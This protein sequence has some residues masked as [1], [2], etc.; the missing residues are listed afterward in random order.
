LKYLQSTVAVN[1]IDS[2]TLQRIL[3]SEQ[4]PFPCRPRLLL[5]VLPEHLLHRPH[6]HS[7]IHGQLHWHH[8]FVVHC[9][10]GD[11]HHITALVQDYARPEGISPV[12]PNQGSMWRSCWITL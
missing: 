9:V 5:V 2:N 10:Y 4:L 12:P 3:G 1:D 7:S 8:H 11:H 6:G